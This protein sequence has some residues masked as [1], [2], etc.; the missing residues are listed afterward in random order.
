M[1]SRFV[2]DEND[3]LLKNW[4]LLVKTWTLEKVQMYSLEYLRNW[5]AGQ[6]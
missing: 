6:Y 5:Q 2:V 3:M 4:K 1:A